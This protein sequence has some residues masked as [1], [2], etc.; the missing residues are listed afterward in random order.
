M[1]KV[2]LVLALVLMLMPLC[3]LAQG[4]GWI[5]SNP[6]STWVNLR[7][8]PTTQS[9]SLGRYSNGTELILL[10][11]TDNGWYQVAVDG[12]TGYMLQSM[13]ARVYSL[14]DDV[15]TVGCTN[16]DQYIQSVTAPNGQTLYFISLEKQPKIKM[17]DVNFDGLSDI[18]V[19]TAL[20]ASNHFCE[21]FVS[22]GEMYHYVKHPLYGEGLCNY[23]LYPEK[24]LVMTQSNSGYA[25][26][27]HEYWILR[28]EGRELTLM[29]RAHS[30]ELT[31][32]EWLDDRRITTAYDQTLHVTIRDYT[33]ADL[34]GTVIWDE[35]IEL[36]KADQAFFERERKALWE[37][38]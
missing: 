30:R 34:D 8:E 1:K 3:A 23:Q 9:H 4:S 17:E 35:T 37:G 28:W 7:Q 31:E 29:R 6:N 25:G 12:K 13:V 16:D 24:N 19:F 27:L 33:T 26:A 14:A 38:L 5:V 10:G 22:D 11:E 2:F 15:R 21:F 20:G 32:T 36:E 18:V